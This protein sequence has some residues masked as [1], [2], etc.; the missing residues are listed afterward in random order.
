[1][2][3]FVVL[4]MFGREVFVA[5]MPFS[6]L[7]LNAVAETNVPAIPRARAFHVVPPFVVM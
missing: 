4:A 7:S 1:M 3:P 6:L 2:P 5:A